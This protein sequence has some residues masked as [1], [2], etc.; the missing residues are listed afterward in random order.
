MPAYKILTSAS[1]IQVLSSTATV[2]AVMVTI[3]TLPHNVT[4][5]ITMPEETFAVNLGDNLLTPYRNVIEQIMGDGKV[6]AATG[7]QTL[8]EN[9]LLKDAITWTVGYTPAG[10]PAGPLTVQVTTTL[11]TPVNSTTLLVD[12]LEES[13]AAIDAAYQNLAGAPSY[14]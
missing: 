13:E 11:V 4:A 1:T 8:D 7:L 10:A 3:Q 12:Y 14:E 9:G 6:I 2:D 5:S